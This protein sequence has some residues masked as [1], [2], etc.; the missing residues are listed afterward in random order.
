MPRT[1]QAQLEQ[2]V[3]TL[4][5]P[6]DAALRAASERQETEGL[7]AIN[8]SPDEG[9]LIS[10]LLRAVGARRVLEIGTLGGYS[11]IWIARALPPG[12]RL[13]TLEI[14]PRHATVA[15]HSFADAGLSDRVE[16][17]EGFAR[18]ILPTLEPGF[19][20]VFIDADKQSQVFYFH[21]S[22]RLLRVGGLLLCDN[23]YLDGRVVLARDKK[24]EVEAVREFNRLAATD[25]RLA[26]TIVP[27]RDGLVVG[28]K[29]SA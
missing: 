23:A 20:A 21:Q 1:K 17:R 2:Y 18:E 22:M 3:R 19:D 29:I 12:G 15:R 11:G 24:P 6:E 7:P 27:V 10:L 9:K 28:V 8:I 13:T 16:L 26:A 4:F 5:A 14:D 25:A